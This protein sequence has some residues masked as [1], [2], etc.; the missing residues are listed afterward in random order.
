M[1]DS[2]IEADAALHPR[3]PGGGRVKKEREKKRER[4]D[5]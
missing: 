2:T 3:M 5:S 1:T 4:G